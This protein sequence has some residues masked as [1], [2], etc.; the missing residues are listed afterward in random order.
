MRSF[1][2]RVVAWQRRHGRHDLPWQTRDPYR[3]WLA[4]VM[5]QQTQVATVLPYYARFLQRFP[6]LAA[7]AAAPAAEVMR[8]WSGLGYYARARHLHACARALVERHGSRFP[9]TAAELQRLPGVGRSTA[10]AIAACC[11][12]ER[13]AIL[14]G[15]VRRVLARHGG[16]EGNP[17]AAPVRERLWARAEALLPPARA[18]RAYTQG[19]M[20][21]GA[22][23]CVRAAP[24]C[25]DCPVRN[26]CVALRED[27]IEALTGRGARRPARLRR[28]HWLLVVVRGRVLLERQPAPGVWGGLLAPPRYATAAAV[29]AAV[30]QGGSTVR[31]RALPARRHAFTHFTL[32]F[33]PHVLRLARAPRLPHAPGGGRWVG[34]HDLDAVALPAPVRSLLV[35]LRDLP[36][37]RVAA[38]RHRATSGP[39]AGAGTG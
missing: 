17:A 12:D 18:M 13:A 6:D 30:G 3:V 4:E 37:P 7:L 31:V 34:L 26:D 28:V 16:I 33:T 32:V 27:R 9:A 8:L 11:F 23:V 35:A 38:G 20:D 1:A 15:N 29:R 39:R 14:D 5:L 19:L 36:A 24:R 10:A 22:T 2:A 25:A 21:L